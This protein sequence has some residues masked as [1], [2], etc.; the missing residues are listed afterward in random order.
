MVYLCIYTHYWWVPSLSLEDALGPHKYQVHSFFQPWWYL[1]GGRI[2]TLTYAQPGFMAFGRIPSPMVCICQDL[3]S[4]ELKMNCSS[5]LCGNNAAFLH[6]RSTTLIPWI[7]QI[8]LLPHSWGCSHFEHWSLLHTYGHW[9]WEWYDYLCVSLYSWGCKAKGYALPSHFRNW[10]KL[11]GVGNDS[12]NE[13]IVISSDDDAGTLFRQKK[14][15]CQSKSTSDS[16]GKGKQ[17]AR[18]ETLISDTAEWQALKW[19]FVDTID[20][21][22]MAPE[23]WGIPLKGMVAYVL[24][25]TDN[26]ECLSENDKMLTVDAFIKKEVGT[27]PTLAFDHANFCS[28]KMPGEVQQDQINSQSL[29]LCCCCLM[30]YPAIDQVFIGTASTRVTR[31]LPIFWKIF[32]DTIQRTRQRMPLLV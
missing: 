23:C 27:D 20:L 13:V 8:L 11:I 32:N 18:S 30:G 7:S 22:T 6:G 28:A 1:S 4:F 29:S 9:Y 5:I 21:I 12:D 17:K 25:L 16:K 10:T 2:T 3:I 19:I 15:C 14:W 31:Q 24:N 26:P